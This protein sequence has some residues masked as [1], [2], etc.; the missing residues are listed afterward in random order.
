MR[1]YHIFVFGVYQRRASSLEKKKPPVIRTGRESDVILF[2][3]HEHIMDSSFPTNSWIYFF[4]SIF[5][6]LKIKT[7]KIIHFL[8][9]PVYYNTYY[10]G[11][12]TWHTCVG[13]F[14]ISERRVCVCVSILCEG[15]T[16]TSYLRIYAHKRV[17]TTSA[18]KKHTII[19]HLRLR[20]SARGAILKF[21]FF[22][23]PR[24]PV[25]ELLKKKRNTTST[26]FDTFSC[27]IRRRRR[28][29]RYFYNFIV[30]E[31]VERFIDAFLFTSI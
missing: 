1:I 25:N 16:R 10:S 29:R 28:R 31:D 8:R 11:R 24:S 4:Q 21:F 30:Y 9:P 2:Y 6:F 22:F 7:K 20:H 14:W 27:S 12:R 18:H 5:F 23:F 3:T 15:D 19:S 17:Y 26:Y 13:Y